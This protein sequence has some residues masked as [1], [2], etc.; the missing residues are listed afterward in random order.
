MSRHPMLTKY[1]LAAS[2]LAKQCGIP[3][4]LL[5]PQRIRISFDIDDTLACQLADCG[6]TAFPHP[7]PLPGGE[8]LLIF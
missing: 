8:G 7:G 4:S 3:T 6:L 5:K 1:R 2:R